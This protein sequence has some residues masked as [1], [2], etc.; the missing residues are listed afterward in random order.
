MLDWPSFHQESQ[1]KFG[2]PD[3][4]GRNMDAWVDCMSSLRDEDSMASVVLQSDEI[5]Q[6]DVAHASL[7]RTKASHILDALEDCIDAVNERYDENGEIPAL[8]LNLL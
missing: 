4:Y 2:F 3:F 7:L 5:L 1:H 8:K 6:I